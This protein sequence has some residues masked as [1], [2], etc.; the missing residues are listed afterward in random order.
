M[1]QRPSWLTDSPIVNKEWVIVDTAVTIRARNYRRSLRRTWECN[2]FSGI[3]DDIRTLYLEGDLKAP[4]GPK[5]YQDI[6]K[7]LKEACNQNDVEKVV[8]AYTLA[9]SFHALVNSHLA[10]LVSTN[11]LKDIGMDPDAPFMTYWYGPLDFACI[12]VYDQQLEKYRPNQNQ[13]VYRGMT[14]PQEVVVS[15][16]VGTRLMNKT[17]VSTSK[18][19]Q[20]ALYFTGKC[21][22]LVTCICIY[23]LKPGVRRT[24][25]DITNL[26][27]VEGEEEIIILPYS[28]FEVTNVRL[29][30]NE[31][32]SIDYTIELQECHNEIDD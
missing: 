22:D 13:K 26:S 25:L 15:Y 21:P 30:A 5:A 24:A 14:V 3:V 19:K 17:F 7:L 12:L 6:D 28:T 2:S 16:R 20:V 32:D 1:G 10:N 8:K 4:L 29:T 31:P 23:T 11:N 9:N 27:A 18:C